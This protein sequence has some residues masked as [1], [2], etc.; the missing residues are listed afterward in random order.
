MLE[1]E[2]SS[3]GIVSI[4]SVIDEIKNNRLKIIDI[5]GVDIAREFSF[6]VRHGGTAERVDKFISFA[7]YW[8]ENN[9]P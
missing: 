4:I 8:V 9:I 5:D 6:V 2:K 3:F 1:R 7:N